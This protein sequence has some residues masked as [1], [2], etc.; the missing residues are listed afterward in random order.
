MSFNFK[1]NQFYKIMNENGGKVID[2]AHE[3]T[4]NGANIQQYDY[5]GGANQ[6]WVFFQLDGGY[7]AITNRNSGKVV[8]VDHGS[9]GNGA[10][11]QQYDYNG[12]A[13]QQWSFQEVGPFEL[14]TPIQ[15]QSLP[16]VPQ[17]TSADEGTLPDQTDPV[18]TAY[19]L[20]PCITVN[21]NNWSSITKITDSPYY[22]LTKT[23]YWKKIDSHTFAPNTKYTSTTE[24]GMTQTDQ[25]SMT[26]TI[27]I[28][29]TA[30]AG[31]SFGK[32]SNSISTTVTNELQVSKSTTTELM[33]DLTTTEEISNP[34]KYEIK[35][36]KYALVTQYDLKRTDGTSVTSSWTVIDKNEEQ[37]SYYPLSSP[38]EVIS[39]DSKE[40]V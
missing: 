23:Q 18:I 10:N 24:Y 29:V 36:T 21:D 27:S 25:E 28:S 7:Y 15:T 8:D 33:T 38:P 11:I 9:T 2:V 31:F 14:P 19:T 39:E 17:Y 13:N 1:N 32:M 12:G 6:Q 40:S 4:G 35:W 34:Y 20:M 30:D 22:M 5:N 26:E 37:E 3:S 16:D